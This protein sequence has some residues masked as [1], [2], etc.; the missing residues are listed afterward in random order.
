MFT[1]VLTSPKIVM[2][3]FLYLFGLFLYR[4]LRI[5]FSRV[6]ITPYPTYALTP[7]NIL[8]LTFGSFLLIM[9]EY[10]L[11]YTFFLIIFSTFAISFAQSS[12][13]LVIAFAMSGG[14][15]LLIRPQ[16]PFTSSVNYVIS[17]YLSQF[18]KSLN[19]LLFGLIFQSLSNE[20]LNSMTED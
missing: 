3:R 20:Q 6:Y 15:L 10:R 11:G 17:D 13:A 5:F 4:Q 14:L 18:L 2:A 16:T 12:I 7:S 8:H 19:F 1:K 9:F